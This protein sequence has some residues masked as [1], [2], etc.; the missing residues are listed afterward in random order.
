MS[1]PWLIDVEPYVLGCLDEPERTA[2]EEHLRGCPSCRAAVDEVGPLPA[3]LDLVPP[4]LI[5]Q[6]ADRDAV[7]AA[8]PGPLAEQVPDSVLAGLLWSV[9]RREAQRRRRRWVAGALAA[10]AVLVLAILVPASPI[11]PA[12]RSAPPSGREVVLDPVAPS[13][14][15]ATATLTQV[16]WGTRIELE[17]VY[18]STGP[19]D[20]YSPLVDY[21]LVVVAA[22]GS[23]E[24]VA[25]WA[26]VPGRTITVPAASDQPLARIT[27]IR[28]FTSDGRVI[29]E[30]DL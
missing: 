9:R 17:C 14:V 16:A 7:T 5:A 20:P 11:A 26:A 15:M 25:T 19:S 3:L 10:A 12:G 18:R 8:V 2:F 29:L 1:D 28:L 6:I 22:D 21:A 30:A 23:S 13:A 4:E 24:Q 27:S